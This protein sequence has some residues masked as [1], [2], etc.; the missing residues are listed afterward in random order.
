MVCFQLTILSLTS[1]SSVIDA[2][3]LIYTFL[4]T[5]SVFLQLR[6]LENVF[7]G[8]ISSCTRDMKF[9]TCG[10]SAGFL[11]PIFLFL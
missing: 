9:I 7:L 6:K 3:M 1:H 5:F 10:L 2:V 8:H 4:I 11:L